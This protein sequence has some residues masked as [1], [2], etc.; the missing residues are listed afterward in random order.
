MKLDFRRSARAFHATVT[1][2]N[3]SADAVSDVTTTAACDGRPLPVSR[4]SLVY[5]EPDRPAGAFALDDT[6]S[7]PTAIT[8][9]ASGTVMSVDVARCQ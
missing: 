6:A 4:S 7:V 8:A 3:G 9:R 2:L 5:V 1:G